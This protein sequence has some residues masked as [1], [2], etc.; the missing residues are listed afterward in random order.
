MTHCTARRLVPIFLLALT[1]G[2]CSSEFTLVSSPNLY[3][4]SSDD[5]FATVPAPLQTTTAPVVFATDRQT[6]PKAE[7][8]TY[9]FERSRSLAVGVCTVT[10]GEQSTWDQLA[11]D[12][13]VAKREYKW[14]LAVTEI[15]ERCHFPALGPPV[16]V[17]GKWMDDP[18]YTKEVAEITMQVHQLL[19]E[20]LAHT[21]V[22]EVYLF[23]HGYN[24]SFDEGA[25]RSAQIW[26]FIG[27][28]GIPVLYSWPAGSGGLLRGYTHDRESGEFTNPHLK[29]FL[30]AVV[31]CPD[32]QK[33]HLIAHSRGT[34]ILATA[35]RELHIAYAAAGKDTRVEMKLGQVVLAAPDIDL[36]VF[37]E[38][39]S[40]DRVGFVAERMTVYVSA[41]DK[42]VDLSNWLFGGVRRLGQI[43]KGDLSPEL[44]ALAKK[45]PVLNVVQVTA[46][47]DSTGHAYFLSSPA[48]LSDLILV[49]RDH[50][51]PG[52]ANG[53]PLIDAE[54][55]FWELNDKYPDFAVEATTAATP[56]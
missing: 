52:A 35:L 8:L 9:T 51:K 46:K 25:F 4:E 24:N 29:H 41:G 32:V 33:I 53:R 15:K 22:K 55:G 34:D 2:G 47:T 20:Q 1:L 36:E 6:D 45:H 31:T 3:T 7:T 17:D 5:P 21:P 42:A 14:P 16:E 28:R 50:K 13:R 12:S 43:G 18:A 39:F 26:H 38:R 49:L 40:A 37:I 30:R 10:M 48:A 23:V 54:G 27:R 11:S 44:E 56:D 19:A